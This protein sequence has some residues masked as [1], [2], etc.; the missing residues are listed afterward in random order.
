M[1]NGALL[2][3]SHEFVLWLCSGYVCTALTIY[4]TWKDCRSAQ[5]YYIGAGQLTKCERLP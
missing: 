4:P 3:L 1:T 2:L 5:E